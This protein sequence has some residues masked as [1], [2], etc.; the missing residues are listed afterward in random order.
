[1][2]ILNFG[3]SDSRHG[4]SFYGR[5]SSPVR[6]EPPSPCSLKSKVVLESHDAD[7]EKLFGGHV[8]CRILDSRGERYRLKL[9]KIGG[10]T[11]I[12]PQINISYD[13]FPIA[14]RYG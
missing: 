8:L 13:L 4:V 11:Q 7:L 2:P 6:H 9:R 12:L 14:L 10:V 5:L 3:F 1:M